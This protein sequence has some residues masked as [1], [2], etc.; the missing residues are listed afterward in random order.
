V[1]QF[2]IDGSRSPAAADAGSQGANQGLL[3][4]GVLVTS[5]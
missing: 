2:T 5:G 4:P 1:G 3:D